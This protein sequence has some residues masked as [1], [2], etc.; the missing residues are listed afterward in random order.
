MARAGIRPLRS[1]PVSTASRRDAIR[2]ILAQRTIGSQDDLQRHLEARG[3]RAAQATLSRDLAAL[4]VRRGSGPEGPRYVIDGDTG[5]LPI[6]PVRRLAES[7]E[8]NG[9]MVV[10]RTKASAASTVARA[11]DDARLPDVLGTLAGDDT[12]FVVPGSARG[13]TALVKHLRQLL[14]V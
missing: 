11:L 1:A 13:A 4:G 6:E 8:T 9:L 12:I 7:V 14:G 2:E 5:G 10:V 3:I